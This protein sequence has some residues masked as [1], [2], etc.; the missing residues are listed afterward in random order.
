M[1]ADITP[2]VAASMETPD[3]SPT[4]CNLLKLY[5]FT[6]QTRKYEFR[7]STV[8]ALDHLLSSRS[9]RLGAWNPSDERCDD[10]SALLPDISIT[11]RLDVYSPTL[12]LLKLEYPTQ[13]YHANMVNVGIWLQ[14]YLRRLYPTDKTDFMLQ[15]TL[16]E[17]PFMTTFFTELQYGFYQTSIGTTLPPT[18]AVYLMS[19]ALCLHQLLPA[20][21]SSLCDRPPSLRLLRTVRDVLNG[22]TMCRFEGRYEP[23]TCLHESADDQVSAA[24]PKPT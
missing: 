24:N 6:H 7:F 15:R 9:T 12:E 18:V 10:N 19:N 4:A 21:F 23:D 13:A 14:R 17:A 22:W 3:T 2:L 16:L 5:F 20:D 8:V 11:V 1:N